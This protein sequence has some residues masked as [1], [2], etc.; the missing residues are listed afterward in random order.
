MKTQVKWSI[1]TSALLISMNMGC[2]KSENNKTDDPN[3]PV[4]Q[5]RNDLISL[6]RGKSREI[7]GRLG[8]EESYILM[9][10]YQGSLSSLPIPERLR[11]RLEGIAP[12]KDHEI[13]V[14]A[15]IKGED[16]LEYTEW[17]RGG[18]TYHPYL[19]PVPFIIR[20]NSYRLTNEPDLKLTN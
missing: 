20:G 17:S 15:Y 7:S 16:I 19:K 11:V 1:L 12:A 14:L 13:C 3:S 8:S 5:L 10:G 2:G 4:V 6:A 9:D 18:D